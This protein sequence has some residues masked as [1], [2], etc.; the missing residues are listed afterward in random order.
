[1]PSS[2]AIWTLYGP[3]GSGKSHLI[4]NMLLSSKWYRNAW[5]QLIFMSPTAA[6]DDIMKPLIGMDPELVRFYPK[7]VP[8]VLQKIV[9]ER[10]PK[11][12]EDGSIDFSS[13]IPTSDLPRLWI[14]IDDLCTEVGK[15][16]PRNEAVRLCTM[17]RHCNCSLIFT[18][19]SMTLLTNHIRRCASVSV[20]WRSYDERE[21]E[22]AAKENSGFPGW[23]E[24]YLK[25]TEK[26][27]GFLVTDHRKRKL[28]SAS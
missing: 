14:V 16:G 2:P 19:Q 18:S 17:F 11:T 28:W 21:V 7:Y 23:K 25:A 26:K 9:D 15:G 20:N 10:A 24:K 13:A 4:L 1:M 5:D 8:E 6:G 22:F 3:P 27:H 12:R